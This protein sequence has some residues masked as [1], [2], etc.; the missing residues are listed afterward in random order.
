MFNG[1]GRGEVFVP[2]A[3]LKLWVVPEKQT[4][5]SFEPCLLQLHVRRI[6]V[7]R[8]GTL[9]L[10]EPIVIGKAE[11][12]TCQSIRVFALEVSVLQ[13]WKGQHACGLVLAGGR[14]VRTDLIKNASRGLIDRMVPGVAAPNGR[15]DML[16][17]GEGE[18]GN[19]RGIP[20]RSVVSISRSVSN[21]LV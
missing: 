3:R 16:N 9:P 14:P 2:N 19:R 10:F 12:L 6:T 7:A 5:T 18:M 1:Q 11:Y 15:Q 21:V 4:L 17:P 20:N 8:G 13:R